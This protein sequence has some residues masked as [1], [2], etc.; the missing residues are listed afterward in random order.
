MLNRRSSGVTAALF[1]CTDELEQRWRRD[2]HMEEEF[3]VRDGKV[4]DGLS[5]LLGTTKRRE[6]VISDISAK[7]QDELTVLADFLENVAKRRPKGLT[8][9]NSGHRC[10]NSTF[11][12]MGI[13]NHSLV[14]Y[15]IVFTWVSNFFSLHHD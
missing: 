1:V 8:A 7:L 6:E 4:V 13:L 10:L 2:T 11:C 15:Y 3:S 12:S 5:D 14:C 9:P